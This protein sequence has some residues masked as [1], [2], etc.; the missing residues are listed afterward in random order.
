MESTTTKQTIVNSSTPFQ[1]GV[2]GRTEKVL[3]LVWCLLC[4]LLFIILGPFSAPVVLIAL[5]KF[6]VEQRGQLSEPVSVSWP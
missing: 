2:N 6:G 4:F 1:S 5:A 3:E